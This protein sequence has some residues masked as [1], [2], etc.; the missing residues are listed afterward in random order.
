VRRHASFADRAAYFARFAPRGRWLTFCQGALV[1]TAP[2]M[3]V[4]LLMNSPVVSVTAETKL[5]EAYKLLVQRRISAVPVVAS[6]G[7]P[8]GV[9]S[10]TDLLRIGR[11][12]PMSLAGIQVLDLPSEPVGEHMHAGIVTVTEDTAVPDAAK[13]LAEKHIHRV[14]VAKDGQLTGVFSTEEVLVAVRKKHIQGPI[15]EE[16]TTPVYSL[17]MHAPV[18]EAAARLDHAGV[19]GVAIVDEHGQP[20]GVFTKTEALKARDLPADTKVE[21]VMSYAI[22]YQHARTPIFRA[23]A[24]AYE[25]GTRRVLVMEDRKLVGVLTGLDFAR[26]LAR[27]A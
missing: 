12:Q 23:A 26:V 2:A 21:D 10:E 14:Y 5:D 15:V 19:S 6:D 3:T 18:A 17:F 7:R 22:L 24:H 8:V 13:I 1:M 25:T 11:M 16:M 27:A 20:V 9:L 4:S